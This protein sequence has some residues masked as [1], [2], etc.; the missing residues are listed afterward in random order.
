MAAPSNSQDAGTGPVLAVGE[1]LILGDSQASV[2]D[3]LPERRAIQAFI[4]AVVQS[5]HL[6]LLVGS[7]LTTALGVAAN[8]TVK[9]DM[10][11]AIETSSSELDA[12]IESAAKASAAAVGRGDAPNVEDRLRVAITVQEGL[13]LVDDSRAQLVES[14]VKSTI[15]SLRRSVGELEAAI[16]HA[17]VPQADGGLGPGPLVTSFLSSFAGRVPTRDRLHIFTTNYDRVLEWGAEQAGLRLVDRFVG[18]L[19][20]VFRSSR[21][22]I[23]YHY[24]PPGSPKEPRHLD[25]VA[26]LTKLHGSLD[27]TWRSEDRQVVRR[28]SAF[29]A[30]DASEVSD[31]L[32]Y[33]NAAKDYETTFYPYADLFR[34]FSAAICR[35]NSTLVTYGYSFG[36]D[37][38]NRTIRDMLTIPSTHLL[39]ISYSDEGSR[40]SQF[41]EDYRRTGQ[42]SLLLGPTLASLDDL[43]RQWLPQSAAGA[44]TK[45]QSDLLAATAAAASPTTAAI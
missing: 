35:P 5:E 25:G 7:G 45:M 19:E 32:I 44:L 4:A 29:G 1:R 30:S 2:G 40:I 31:L 9:A 16:G 39:I 33:P 6:N 34:D 38:I 11:A 36:D 8:A 43:T 14:A 27:W 42:V 10:T 24:T 18:S 28:P 41:I 13:K 12:A 26:R 20:P 3:Q 15:G 21:L 23:D 17:L 37:H 22:E